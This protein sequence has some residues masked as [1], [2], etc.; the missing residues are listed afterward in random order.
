MTHTRL[1]SGVSLLAAAALTGAV[2]PA[3]AAAEAPTI[4]PARARATVVDTSGAEGSW[5]RPSEAL[6]GRVWT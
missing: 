6:I 1:H 2:A 5:G 4:S 3:H